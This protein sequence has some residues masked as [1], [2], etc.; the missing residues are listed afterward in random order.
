VEEV[1]LEVLLVHLV[2]LVK[3]LVLHQQSD[4]KH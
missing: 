1:V 4:L 3:V 2:V